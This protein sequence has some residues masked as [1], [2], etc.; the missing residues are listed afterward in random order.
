MRI[1][2]ILPI[3]NAEKYLSEAIGSILS[4]TYTDFELLA[5]DDG[6]TDKSLDTLKSFTDPR[7]KIIQNNE[8]SGLISTLNKG[9]RL[10]EGEY[11]ARMDA[12]DISLPT[13]FEKQVDLLDNNPEIGV[14]S[15]WIEF[16][17]DSHEIIKFPLEHEE[18]YF[19]FLLG[20][21]VGHANSMIRRDILEKFN[22]R[23]NRDYIHSEDTNLWVNLL[24]LTRFANIPEILY[25][26]RKYDQQ[27]TQ[28]YGETV[29]D[30][31]QRAINIHFSN[32]LKL[33]SISIDDT[34][35]LHP[36]T[37]IDAEYL[38]RFEYITSELI[39]QNKI[40]HRFNEKIVK[41]VIIQLWKDKIKQCNL[42]LRENFKRLFLSDFQ[43]YTEFPIAKRTKFFLKLV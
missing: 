2:V 16:F 27:V 25:R 43:K 7:I 4:Q 35:K 24:P 6:S 15:T 19:R 26:Y 22:I 8:N 39:I 32:I 30:S 38:D 10:A 40:Q 36:L 23:Y 11:I 28:M 18:I 17:G 5:I 12:D 20:V 1:S 37:E 3:Y 33:F 41:S 34:F 29:N 21:Q 42:S 13:R 14:C 9:I 31:F